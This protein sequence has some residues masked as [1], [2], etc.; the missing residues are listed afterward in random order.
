MSITVK[1]CNAILFDRFYSSD[2]ISYAVVS[3]ALDYAYSA[4][5]AFVKP[6]FWMSSSVLVLILHF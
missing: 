6:K 3:W 1:F 4:L 5:M 2:V